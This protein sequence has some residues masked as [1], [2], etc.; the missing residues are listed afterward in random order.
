[1]VNLPLCNI[2]Y[3][4]ALIAENHTQKSKF[5]KK[6]FLLF[7]L[8]GITLSA[9]SQELRVDDDE[10][11][12][13]KDV[14]AK[15]EKVK[16]NIPSQPLFNLVN[17]AG[18]LMAS[19]KE[20]LYLP[21]PGAI[22]ES[23]YSISFPALNDSVQL[24][25]DDFKTIQKIPL[26]GMKGE[27]YAKFYFKANLVNKDGTVNKDAF[28]ELKKKFPDDL[29]AKFAAKATEAAKAAQSFTQLPV[30]DKAQ[31]VV[32]T[33]I[34]RE[35]TTKG[36]V[37]EITYE[38]KQGGVLIGTAVASGHPSTAK[39]DRAEVDYA[40]GIVSLDGEDAPL[41]YDIKNT[42]GA[43]AA[44]YSGTGRKIT[45]AKDNVS[46]SINTLIG[47]R[48][49]EVQTRI[50]MIKETANYLVVGGYM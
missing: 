39:D 20:Y 29:K 38:I 3:V 44:T 4:K 19:S 33:E 48:S 40:P 11:K 10:L 27:T 43:S 7:L 42:A 32:I 17:Q 8:S 26:F 1:M 15:I 25:Y 24:T 36:K 37:M 47:K 28:T 50:D 13:D 16:T 5:M 9:F 12:V 14:V 2:T 49:N 22:A 18:Q 35:E 23:W 6:Q 21:K 30:R 46:K 41:N 31:P 45:T 34:K